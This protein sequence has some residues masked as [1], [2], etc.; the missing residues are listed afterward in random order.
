MPAWNSFGGRIAPLDTFQH[1]VPGGITFLTKI[2][3][4]HAAGV[5]RPL[6]LFLLHMHG[7]VT[8]CNMRNAEYIYFTTSATSWVCRT[9]Q[10]TGMAIAALKSQLGSCLVRQIAQKKGGEKKKVSLRPS[11]STAIILGVHRG[12][13]M[14]IGRAENKNLPVLSAGSSYWILLARSI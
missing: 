3:T 11:S 7:V 5:C 1:V 12:L 14:I 8:T 4:S 6:S 2:Y 13:S 10:C 9:R